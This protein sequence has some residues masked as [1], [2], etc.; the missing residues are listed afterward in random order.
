MLWVADAIAWALGRGGEWKR[1]VAGLLRARSAPSPDARNPTSHRPEIGRAH[2]RKLSAAGTSVCHGGG[3]DGRRTDVAQT[4]ACHRG[5]ERTTA[6]ASS[7]RRKVCRMRT[8]RARVTMSEVKPVV[9]PRNPGLPDASSLA[10]NMWRKA[11]ADLQ[12]PGREATASAR[13]ARREPPFGSDGAESTCWT[14]QASRHRLLRRDILL[15]SVTD[16]SPASIL[17]ASRLGAGRIELQS[18]SAP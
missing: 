12:A 2:F 13:R 18:Y 1:R 9:V 14:L 5:R 4:T 15:P 3:L 8:F 10:P 11:P 7:R 16:G 17:A 6:I